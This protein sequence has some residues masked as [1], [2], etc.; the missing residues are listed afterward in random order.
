MY[1]WI[2]QNEPN[3]LSTASQQKTIYAIDRELKQ[4]KDLMKIVL[5]AFQP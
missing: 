3:L 4:R 2:F 1:D 5:S